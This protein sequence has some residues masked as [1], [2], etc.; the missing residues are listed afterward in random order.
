MTTVRGEAASRVG[1]PG[2]LE[3]RTAPLLDAGSR[4]VVV[5]SGVGNIPNAVRGLQRLGAQVTV[6]DEPHLVARAE[7]VVLPGVGAFPA[8]MA[9]LR[10]RGLDGAI[11]EAAGRGAPLLG[12]CLGHQLLF[13]GS[14]EFG[15]T[16]GLGLLAGVVAPLPPVARVPHMG[17]SPLQVMTPDPLVAGLDGEFFYFVHSFAAIEAPAMIATAPF[18][19]TRICAVVRDGNVCGAQFHPEKSGRA[20][21]S[22]LAGFLRLPC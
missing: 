20:G 6:T 16:R 4:V 18:G 7:R 22:F 15:A 14:E 2:E 21:A 8:A 19:P 1:A 17:W 12:I 9:R 3:D 13:E 11:R 10:G 5:D